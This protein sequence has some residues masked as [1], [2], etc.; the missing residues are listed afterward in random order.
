MRDNP[1][2]GQMGLV[3]LAAVLV[4]VL[5]PPLGL[6]PQPAAAQENW[7]DKAANQTIATFDGTGADGGLQRVRARGVGRARGGVSGTF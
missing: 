6:S 7:L 1:M 4:P 2:V 3:L 5:G